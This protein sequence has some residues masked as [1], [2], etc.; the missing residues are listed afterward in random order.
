MGTLL[1]LFS[2]CRCKGSKTMDACNISIRA[3]CASRKPIGFHCWNLSRVK[4]T[5]SGHHKIHRRLSQTG[6]SIMN[7]DILSRLQAAQSDEERQWITL[8]FSLQNQPPMV[9]EA[10]WAAAIPHWFD[11][12]F[13]GALLEK[14]TFDESPEYQ[15]LLELSFIEPYPERGYS[16]HERTRTV[17]LDR[18]WTEDRD[19]YKELSKRAFE[20]STQY[21]THDTL[22]FSESCYH[23]LHSDI[24]EVVDR[25]MN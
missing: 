18:L 9:R 4:W 8:E 21:E 1:L 17:L 14:E 19:R 22:W 24:P 11:G 16:V 2:S 15:A 13:L 7:D 6:I 5:T 10:V 25:F 3:H 23:G 20:Y 12:K